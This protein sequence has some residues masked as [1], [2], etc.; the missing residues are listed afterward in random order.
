LV[1][2]PI[3]RIIA[4]SQFVESRLIESGVVA[5]K[6]HVVYNGVDLTRFTPDGNGRE[7][8]RSIYG[9]EPQEI[10]LTTV[11]RLWAIKGVDTLLKACAAIK[12]RGLQFRF[13]I[14]G[15]GPQ[16]Q[17]LRALSSSLGLD[18]RVIWIGSTS[19]PELLLR[20][21]DIFLLGTTGEAFGNVLIE[22]MACGSTVVASRSG[23]IPEII[24]DGECGLLADPRDPESFAEKILQIAKN[25]K[26]QV[27]LTNNA[28]N[29][30]GEF[31]VDRAVEKTLDIYG[32]I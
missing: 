25:R 22:A 12:D 28:T 14:A 26:L 9:I 6:I 20:G 17:E 24:T 23:A 11:S 8:L 7:R 10:I 29:Q 4:I 16:E 27:R 21:T 18:S 5:R 19:E 3:Y 15:A 1:T 31:R 2:T 13:L 32:Q 30:A